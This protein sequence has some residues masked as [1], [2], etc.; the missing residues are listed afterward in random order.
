VAGRARQT[1]E[2]GAYGLLALPNVKM[3]KEIDG[4]ARHA[5]REKMR[6]GELAR[7]LT[8]G[9]SRAVAFSRGPS[10]ARGSELLTGHCIARRKPL[11]RQRYPRGRG[12]CSGVLAGLVCGITA[13]QCENSQTDRENSACD[14]QQR[15][16][17]QTL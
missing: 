5:G 3:R 4:E 9:K 17:S 11:V 12:V 2:E 7:A 1:A 14:Q 16:C 10:L 6:A 13:A 15:I 8:A